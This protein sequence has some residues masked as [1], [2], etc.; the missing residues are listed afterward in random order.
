MNKREVRKEALYLIQANIENWNYD[1]ARGVAN[2]AHGIG[3]IT[4]IEYEKAC[5][6]IRKAENA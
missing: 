4:D 2:L 5:D 1:V 3:A 6:R